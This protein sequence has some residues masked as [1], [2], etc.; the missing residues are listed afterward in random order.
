[1]VK[2]SG[3]NVKNP[4]GEAPTHAPISAPNL[5]RTTSPD[6]KPQARALERALGVSE[7]LTPM[8]DGL[9]APLGRGAGILKGG[10]GSLDFVP[11]PGTLRASLQRRRSAPA[12]IPLADARSGTALAQ[13]GARARVSPIAVR[14]LP[15]SEPRRETSAKPSIPHPVTIAPERPFGRGSNAA[16]RLFFL[17]GTDF[18]YNE[19]DD[20]LHDLKF[21]RTAPGKGRQVTLQDGEF[22]DLLKWGRYYILSAGDHPDTAAENQS[23]A[24]DATER[25]EALKADL[26]A[27]GY[28][29]IEVDGNFGGFDEKSVIGLARDGRCGDMLGSITGGR[30]DGILGNE[31]TRF[32][33]DLGEKYGQHSIIH[34]TG[35]RHVLIHTTGEDKGRLL[36]GEHCDVFDGRPDN[37]HSKVTVEA[38]DG[39]RHAYYFQLN[40]DLMPFRDVSALARELRAG[41]ANQYESFY[42]LRQDPATGQLVFPELRDPVGRSSDRRFYIMRG[43]A[44]VTRAAAMILDAFRQLGADVESVSTDAHIHAANAEH[45]A[46]WTRLT[47][48]RAASPELEAKTDDQL[49]R[50]NGDFRTD[51]DLLMAH[52]LAGL[53]DK[54]A[55]AAEPLETFR[56]RPW[57]K[58]HSAAQIEADYLEAQ[59]SAAELPGREVLAEVRAA[60]PALEALSD[61]EV[62]ARLGAA[63]PEL[64]SVRLVEPSREPYRGPWWP[65]VRATF[66]QRNREGLEHLFK[67]GVGTIIYDDMNLN[68]AYFSGFAARARAEGY[69]VEILQVGGPNDGRGTYPA[70]A[71][72]AKAYE[73]HD[74]PEIELSEGLVVKQRPALELL[75]VL[76]RSN[77]G[78]GAAPVALE[79]EGRP[80]ASPLTA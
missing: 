58:K 17:S 39:T 47:E 66:V 77:P 45:K 54:A 64:A 65:K 38:K 13:G 48:L 5:V 41:Q 9:D 22:S 29:F 51:Y 56:A 76:E 42:C 30:E 12:S 18:Q 15:A 34:A 52:H 20:P 43:T 80:S 49:A 68:P 59:R 35:S 31:D 70:A 21:V 6:P 27:A 71:R 79:P 75:G 62:I 8:S 61:A 40:L 32:F 24:R 11:R 73:K 37:D 72:H 55:G 50:E 14:A 69:H 46:A 33:A 1:M 63:R 4:S 16:N 53:E 57:R 10:P 74:A 78:A 28:N 36:Y 7:Y 3:T 19:K 23:T 2:V 67:A 26:A 60:D 25:H 44:G